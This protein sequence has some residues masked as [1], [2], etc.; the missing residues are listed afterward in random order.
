MKV[1]E[2]Q[3]DDP[4][5][6]EE[7]HQMMVPIWKAT[8]Q[9]DRVYALRQQAFENLTAFRQG[10]F[11]LFA[12]HK[13]PA[14]PAV[15]PR[16]QEPPQKEEAPDPYPV[17]AAQVLRLIGEFDGSR[18]DYGEDDAQAVENIA[19]Q[20]HDP[21]QREELYELLRSFL[22]HADPEEEIAVDVALCLEQIEALP[23]ALTPEQALREEIKTYLD[24]AGY[25]ASDELI[26]DGIS[27]YRSHGGKGNSQDVAGFI[28]REL[29]AEEPAAEAMPSGH[30]DE[31][32]LLGRLKADCDY[33]LGA[34]GRAEK[35]LWAGNVREQI[36]KMRELYAALPEKPEWLTSEDI[37]RYAQRMEP[38]YE[39]A[40]YHHFE[41]GFDERLDYQ[42]L[43]EAEQAAQQ[44]VA[45]TMEGEDGFAY[46]G[47]GIYDLNERRW[48]RVYG[49]FPD[50]R[51]IEQAALAAEEPQASTEQAGL[52]PKKEEPAPLPPKRPRRERITFTT[53]HPEI[54]R[55]QRHDFHITDDALGH[56]T[57]SEKYAANA[58]AIRTLKQ[59]EAEERLATPEEQ[60]ILS[61]YVGWG[62]LADCF[63]E[64][65]PHY[66]ELKSLLY[67]EEYAAARASTLTAFYTP[68][69]V[70]RGIYKALSQMGFTQGNILEP[71]CG[72]G[73]FLGLLPADMAGS[74]AYGV[75]LDSISGRIAQQLYQNASV[76][77]NGF[78]TV[79][80]PDSFFDVAVGNVPFGDFKVLDRR[81]DKH[82]WLIHDYFF[83]ATRS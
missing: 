46:D 8:P 45:G 49:D 5:C 40:V 29:L 68:P 28:E 31:Y 39:V 38:P 54:S 11:T 20:L 69:V 35:H 10:T 34:G 72:T 9:G 19:R 24:E 27:E 75:E 73:N 4:A 77:V 42:T 15:P 51:A 21:A 12:E 70:I 53:L 3:L 66:E 78:E 2:P 63:E 43:A 55:D 60:E 61:R 57:P 65:S 52:Q 47:A 67:L 26:E 56:G 25:A 80:M 81:Y 7:I 14:A 48:L 82:H 41:N 44:Y 30:G 64:T 18:M 32:R 74:K 13:E 22:D 23:P 58:A 16:V 1:I 62:G 37:D 83:G 76:S 36:A 50:E 17:L 6:V 71:S 79:Q 59:I 33:F